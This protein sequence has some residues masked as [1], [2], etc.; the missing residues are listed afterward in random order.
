MGLW[1]GANWTFMVWGLMH[2]CFIFGYRQTKFLRCK[3]P[4]SLRKYGGWVITLAFVVISWIP[5]RAQ[6][7]T[8]AFIMYGNGTP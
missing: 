5:F 2:A 6:T 8:D 3:F 1:H 4:G 7:L